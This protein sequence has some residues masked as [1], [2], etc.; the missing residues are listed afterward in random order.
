MVLE[1][2]LL[3][4]ERRVAVK[5][6]PPARKNYRR[7]GD[8]RVRDRPTLPSEAV[9]RG[10]LQ[11]QWIDLDGIAIESPFIDLRIDY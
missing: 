8:S 9:A 1:F 10:D 5:V 4:L 11:D 6:L 3:A 2:Y 7:S